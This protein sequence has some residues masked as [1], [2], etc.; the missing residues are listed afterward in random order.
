LRDFAD[1]GERSNFCRLLAASRSVFELPGTRGSNGDG[2]AYERAGRVTLAQSDVLLAVWDGKA[3]RGPGGTGQVVA[4]AVTQGLPVIL[5]DPATTAEV[6]LLWD[7]LTEHDLGQQS[8]D[9]VA[10]GDLSA[11]PRLLAA[12]VARPDGAGDRRALESFPLPGRSRGGVSL[13]YPL[14]QVLVGVRGLRRS[15]FG[16]PAAAAPI[17][18][19]ASSTAGAGS[20]ASAFDDRIDT[21]T[22][23]FARADVEAVVNARAFRS[24]YVSNF[25]LAALA[26]ILSLC[27]LLVP[28]QFKPA[29]VVLEFL[30][31]ASILLITRAGTRQDWHGRWLDHRE[32]A[33]RLRCLALSAQL[34][35]LNLRANRDAASTRLDW[36]AKATARET[37]LPSLVADCSYV[38]EVRDDLRRLLND[39]VAYLTANSRRMNLLEHRLHLIGTALFAA[40]AVVC[41]TVLL[42]VGMESFGGALDDEFGSALTKAAIVISAALPAIGSAIYGIRMQGDF[43]RWSARDAALAERLS[44]L[45]HVVDPDQLSF[46]TLKLR[47][48]RATQL[49]TTELAE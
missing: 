3:P 37:G 18:P 17:V 9:T 36:L 43:G 28:T 33:E 34:G 42:F 29:L 46:D 11:L 40:T 12:L 47:V 20:W 14:L 48:A 32:L 23:R 30:T 49:R 2:V 25:L 39:Q 4:E 15:N 22:A 10:R 16:V 24:S 19:V 6:Q 8:V 38:E 26:V 27:G 45:R 41:V 21:L 5:I 1:A 31:I 7:G 44:A 35:D 13:A